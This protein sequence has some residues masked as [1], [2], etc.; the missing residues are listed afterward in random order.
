MR[1]IPSRYGNELS[2]FHPR[3]CQVVL[4]DGSVHFLSATIDRQTLTRLADPSDGKPV[5]DY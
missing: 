4:C 3:G 1:P 5:G 2:S